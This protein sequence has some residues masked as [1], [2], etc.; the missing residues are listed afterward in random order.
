[1]RTESKSEKTNSILSLEDRKRRKRELV[2]VFAILVA[3]AILTFVVNRVVSFGPDFPVSNTIL[4]FVLINVNLL[5]LLLLIFLVFRNLV[6]LLYDRKRKVI[7]TKLRTRLV[8]SFITLTLLPT[9]VLFFFSIHFITKS[10]QFW[11]NAPVEQAL[12]NS[13][14]VGRLVYSHLEENNRFYL[15]RITYQIK[16]KNLLAPGKTE[17]LNNYIQVVQRAYNLHAVEIYAINFNRIALRVDKDFE[18]LVPEKVTP[19]NLQKAPV[20][21]GIRS[22][23]EE[24][25]GGELFRTIGTIPFKAQ[26]MQTEA[27]VVLSVLIPPELFQD[28]Q[29]ISD[30]FQE[31]Q[32]IKLLKEPIQLTYYVALSIV[33]LLVVF[34]AIWLGLYLAKTI[35]IPIM[36]LSEATLRVAEGNLDVEI[37]VVAD[38]EI[39]SLVDAF[40][41]MTR[42]LRIGRTQLELSAN[43]LRERSVEIEKRRKYMEIVLKNVS[44]GVITLDAY[45]NISSINKSAEKMLLLKS[46][47]LI[48]KSFKR[49]LRGQDI[50]LVEQIL[51]DLQVSRKNVAEVSLRVVID[52][53]PKSFLVNINALSDDM[54]QQIGYVIVLDDLTELEKAQR[55][56]AWREVARRIAH[57]VKNPLTPITLSAQR[58]RRKYSENLES[59]VFDECTQTIIDQVAHIRNLV[60]EFS[61]FAKFPTANLK[62]GELVPIIKDSLALYREGYENI[63]FIFEVK[64]KIPVIN[65]DAQQIK[66]AMINLLDNAIA[67]IKESGHIWVTL[68]H[69]PILKRVRIEVSD[70]GTGIS[71]LNKTRLFEPDFSTK[72]A[73][74]GL[75][76]TIVS[77][78]IADHNGV[79]SVHSNKP[80]GAKFVIELPI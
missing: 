20:S 33:A 11:F 73:G 40:N 34:C 23:S 10:I 32:Q 41:R 22:I 58:L 64:D 31:Y 68:T 61:L 69:D 6:K 37:D 71:D 28:M 3:V 18:S 24:F 1:M 45:G 49:L 78:I 77:S 2:I 65:L 53:K 80:H 56:A 27:F 26:G 63:E 62:P 42:D 55:M 72:K 54:G 47:K 52:D 67:A 50:S 57:E 19:N 39:G 38:D 43:M 59:P 21:G 48:N 36:Q 79:V 15:E 46:E 35:S 29:S 7:G 75:G 5:L 44:T 66:Q 76:L 17:D 25:E 12:E 8:A 74:M 14:K 9:T 60:N 13:L 4:M 70:D 51:K 30:G 16:T